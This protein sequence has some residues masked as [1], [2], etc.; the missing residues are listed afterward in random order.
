MR[1]FGRVLLL[2]SG[3]LLPAMASGQEGPERNEA[4][5]SF[6]YEHFKPHNYQHY[7]QNW[8]IVQDQRGVIY[9]AN[10][11]GV[12]EYDGSQWRLIETAVNTVVRSLTLG[13]DGVGGYTNTAIDLVANLLGAIVGTLYMSARSPQTVT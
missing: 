5:M 9:V 3:L 11:D 4:G 13:T 6:Y 1:F 8:A 2:L 10:K 7:P 12:L